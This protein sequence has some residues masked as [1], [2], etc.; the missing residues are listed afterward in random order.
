MVRIGYFLSCEE[1]GPRELV[2]Q[3]RLAEQAGFDAL[4]VSDHFHPWN[5]QQGNSP[6]VWSVIGALSEATALPVSTAVTCPIMRIHPAVAAQAAATA[7]VQCEGRF[8]LGVGSGEALNEHVVGHRWPPAPVRQDMLEEAVGVIRELHTGREVSHHGRYF[9]VEEARLYTVPDQP[10]PIYISGFGPRSVELAAR[11]GD[12][13]CTTAPDAGMVQRFRD[14]G[15]GSKPVQGGMKV[16]WA[17]TVD[18]GMDTTHRLWPNSAL[19]GQLA[20][21]LPT[22]QD[23]E[24]ASTLVTRELAAEHIP[25][26]PDVKQHVAAVRRFLDAGFDEVYVQQIGPEQDQFFQA[27]SEAVLPELR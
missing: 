13:Y 24:Q 8:V 6:F 19:P 2:R 3:A 9:T 21:T 26:G 27:W 17:E 20:Q 4:W 10:V 22:P 23:F 14:S 5:G 15:G 1:F 25:C 12:G 18:A 16:C 7:A 11:I